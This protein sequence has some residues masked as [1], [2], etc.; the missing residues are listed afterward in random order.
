VDLIYYYPDITESTV[1]M[2]ALL[3]LAPAYPTPLATRALAA[4]THAL[5]A[6]RVA[7]QTFLSLLLAV[8]VGRTKQTAPENLDKTYVR[9]CK[10]C[11]A[12]CQGLQA[13]PGGA[14]EH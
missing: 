13:F 14:G 11:D 1:R 12:A 8:L 5:A 2:L 4:L 6:S 3:C 7:A 10:L 9:A